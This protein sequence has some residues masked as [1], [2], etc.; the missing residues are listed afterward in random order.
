MDAEAEARRPDLKRQAQAWANLKIDPEAELF[1]FVGRWSNQKGIDLIADVFPSILESYPKTQLITVGPVIDL[2]GRFA[3]LKLAKMME[4][5][6]GRVFSKPEFT[7][8]PPFIF[9]GSEFA[10]IPSRDEPFGL[11]AVEFGRKGALGVGA[12]VGGLGQMPGWWYAI[13]SMTPK[14]LVHQFKM[15]IHEALASSPKTRATMRARSAKQRFPVAQWVEDLDTLQSTAIVKSLECEKETKLRSPNGLNSPSLTNLRSLFT[16][17]RTNSGNSTPMGSSTALGTFTPQRASLGKHSSLLAPPTTGSPE[18]PW[19]VSGQWTP[20]RDLPMPPGHQ[21]MITT[22]SGSNSPG[23]PTAQ[24]HDFLLSPPAETLVAPGGFNDDGKSINTSRFST[25]SYDSVA[26]GR[27]NF[28][29]QQVDP[30]F[31]DASGHYLKAFEKKLEA[32]GP[33]SSE[34]IL[35]IE[36]NLIKSEKNF[37][38]DYRAAKMG[39]STPNSRAGSIKA[40][41]INESRPTTP[42]GSYFDHSN[43]GS[44]DS[45]PERGLLIDEFAMAPDYVP[46][47]GLKRLLLYRTGDWPIYTILLAFGQIIAANSYQVTLLVG[48]IGETATQLYVIATIYAVASICFWLL[49]RKVQS[50]YC[51]SIPFAFYGLA[52]AFIGLA[53]FATGF[54]RGW[55]QNT[56]TGLYAVASSSGSLFFAL[57]FGDEGKC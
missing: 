56:A 40:P 8:L 22:F 29:L 27:E 2:Y 48:E 15:A 13:E 10:L 41:S 42:Q 9:S 37:F 26:K 28:A 50:V 4:L 57:N 44:V 36:E 53:P 54:A 7:A 38:N 46:P 16:P 34:N 23:T 11:V 33:K 49:F 35:C 21:S 32:L 1:V 18:A 25:L 20:M 45:M 5:Y 31:T 12:R 14:H 6:P 30:N 39:L 47:T 55:V 3:A 52:F 17:S 24:A 43:H 19:L 51:L